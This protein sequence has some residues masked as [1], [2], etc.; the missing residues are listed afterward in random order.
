MLQEKIGQLLVGSG[1][2]TVLFSYLD[3]QLNKEAK[4]HNNKIIECNYV[5]GKWKFLRVRTDKSFPNSYETATSKWSRI[6]TAKKFK[7]KHGV[8]RIL[9]FLTLGK[10]QKGEESG[11]IKLTHV[12]GL[13]FCKKNHESS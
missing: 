1:R 10:R 4:E 8:A 11:Y 5:D 12:W 13:K 2:Q 6:Y 9:H 7:N 3:L